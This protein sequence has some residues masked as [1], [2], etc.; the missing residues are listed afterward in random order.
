MEITEPCQWV[1]ILKEV[2]PCKPLVNET[3]M[4]PIVIGGRAIQINQNQGA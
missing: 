1:V 4:C 3:T 2:S